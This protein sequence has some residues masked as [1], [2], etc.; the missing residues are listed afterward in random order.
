MTW[1]WDLTRGE[2]ISYHF[3]QFILI[4]VTQIFNSVFYYLSENVSRVLVLSCMPSFKRSLH[5]INEGRPIWSD[6]I[7]D[8][9]KLKHGKTPPPHSVDVKPHAR[10]DNDVTR[11]STDWKL[12]SLPCLLFTFFC[13]K[14][15]D[16]TY[17]AT[18]YC[19]IVTPHASTIH[20][21]PRDNMPSRIIHLVFKDSMNLD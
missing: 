7:D 15:N 10:D 4:K 16:R 5:N 18:L 17:N 9:C 6:P 8:R 11:F 3:N 13:P 21:G 12:W 14:S 2:E 1:T 20:M 19:P